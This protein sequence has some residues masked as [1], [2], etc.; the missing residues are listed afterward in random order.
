MRWSPFHT[1][2]PRNYSRLMAESVLTL[3]GTRSPV[4][5]FFLLEWH[6]SELSHECVRR[7]KTHTF[8]YILRSG[9]GRVG[10][11]ICGNNLRSKQTETIFPCIAN[12]TSLKK[13]A[14][15]CS[16]GFNM[17]LASFS[18]TLK[19]KLFHSVLLFSSPAEC[20]MNTLM[21]GRHSTQIRSPTWMISCASVKCFR[22]L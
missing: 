20:V 22:T 17:A 3:H 21:I 4:L 2:C 15:C 6:R 9:L 19:C 12:C 7:K 11:F 13:N 1:C 10:S 16:I 14:D 5:D 8:E 18:S